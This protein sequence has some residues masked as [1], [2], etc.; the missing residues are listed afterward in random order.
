MRPISN[1]VDIT[2]YVDARPRQPAARLRPREDPRRELTARRARPVEKLRTLDGK[3]RELDA[4]DAGDR[5]RRGAAGHRRHHGRRGT[6]RSATTRHESCS[7]RRT[8]RARRSCAPRR[9]SACARTAR[10]AGRR[11]STRPRADRLARRRAAAR[12]ALRRRHGAAS[13]STCPATCRRARS[14]GCAMGRV[15]QVTAL[16]RA[17][18]ARARSSTGSASSREPDEGT[19]DV[20]VPTTALRRRHARDRPGRGGR[21]HLRPRARALDAARSARRRRPDAGQRVRR[22]LE[23]AAVGAGLNGGRRR[24]RMVRRGRDRARPRRPTIR[25][26]RAAPLANPL[27]AEHDRTAHDAAAEPARVAPPQ[28]G[29]G[30]RRTRASS[31]SRTSYH[32]V[33]GARSCRASR[34]RSA[35]RSG[36]RGRLQLARRGPARRRSSRPRAC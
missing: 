19:I 22:A 8:S 24:S 34:G 13:R 28:R 18:G 32:P 2:N 5:R 9:R 20:R 3:E 36:P 1:V 35:R 29:G 23:D 14:C 4:D 31:R 10:T 33:D 30:P 17:R 12:R 26:R 15:A 21:A 6:R 27:S 11:A 7:R 16:D 25:A